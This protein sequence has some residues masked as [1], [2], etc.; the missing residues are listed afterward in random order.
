M[1]SFAE[2]FPPP[3]LLIHRDLLQPGTEAAYGEI[4]EDTARLMR[5]ALPLASERSVQFPN[6][7][8]AIEALTGPKEVWFLTGWQSMADYDQVGSD[9]AAK[10]GTPLVAALERNSGRKSAFIFE[11]VSVFA[12]YRQELSRGEQWYL[13]HGRFLAIAITRRNGPFHGTV[14]E[15][16]DHARFV[17]QA[18]QTRVEAESIAAS[19]GSETKVFAIRPNWTRP[20]TEWVAADPAFWQPIAN[21]AG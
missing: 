3:I 11:Q 18:A 15:A 7:Y 2:P 14:F 8:L 20:A 19:S 1:Q 4:E 16:D 12:T 13:G 9:Y 6:S 10:A 17:I 21:G 5:D